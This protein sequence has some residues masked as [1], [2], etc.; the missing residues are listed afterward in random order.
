MH[1]DVSYS[2][3]QALD[4]IRARLDGVFDDPQLM[5]LGPLGDTTDDI[6]RIIAAA[7]PPAAN[8]D[9]PVIAVIVAQSLIDRVVSD[10]PRLIGAP[11]VIIDY[12]TEGMDEAEIKTLRFRDSTTAPALLTHTVIEPSDVAEPGLASLSD[13]TG[14]APA[15]A[16]TSNPAFAVVLEGGLVSCVVSNDT[17]M[18][19]TNFVIVDYDTDGADQDELLAVPQED[20]SMAEAVGR[21]DEISRAGIDIA[22]IAPPADPETEA[23]DAPAPVA[24]H[25]FHA[26]LLASYP[27]VDLLPFDPSD[28]SAVDAAVRNNETGDTLFNFLWRE[29]SDLAPDDREDALARILAVERDVQAV[30]RALAGG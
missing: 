28:Y 6:R 21:F 7:A 16:P 11:C 5:R 3:A 2:S 18:I 10:D 22:R 20:G 26:L 14:D 29:L 30:Y 8:S 4:A 9:K 25:P 27:N 24:P 15:P 19:G 23:G 13:A 1:I 17:R 12:D